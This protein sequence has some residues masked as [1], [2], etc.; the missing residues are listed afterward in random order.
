MAY[1]IIIK[2]AAQHDLDK[3]PVKEVVRIALRIQTLEDNPRPFGI[4]KL[5]VDEGYRIRSGNYRILFEIDDK[6]KLIFIYRIKH[7]KDVYR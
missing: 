3:L 6:E 7:R 4:Q 1:N 2:P 5:S